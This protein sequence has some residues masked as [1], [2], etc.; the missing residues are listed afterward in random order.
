[1]N[2]VIKIKVCGLTSADDLGVCQEMG[3]DFTGFIFHPGSPRY[4]TPEKIGKWS[5]KNELRVGVFVNAAE[6]D[7]LETVD[8]AGLD[9]VQL[10]GGQN[11]DFCR[12]LGADMVIKTFWPE[13]FQNSSEF[14]AE[15][16]RFKETCRY[17]LLD[18]GRSMGGHGRSIACDW[19]QD[20]KSPLPFFMAGGLGPDNLDQV[21]RTQASG[22]DLNSG[23]EKGPGQKD[24][25][26]IKKAVSKLR[27][28]K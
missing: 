25:E 22:V 12:G 6:K 1:M 4:V 8:R 13:L 23:V 19:L 11:P 2:R 15:L 21:L 27:G 18:A 3:I 20:L 7:V 24:H 9:M 10:H 16:Q 14:Q 17:F 28:I 26:K 5:K